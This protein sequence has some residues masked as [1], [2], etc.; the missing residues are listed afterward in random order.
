[1]LGRAT[2]GAYDIHWM[3]S[4]PLSKLYE[5]IEQMC[6]IQKAENNGN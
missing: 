3:Q 6:A 1:M 2:N 5:A 4:A